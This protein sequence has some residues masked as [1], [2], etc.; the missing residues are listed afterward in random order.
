MELLPHTSSWVYGVFQGMCIALGPLQLNLMFLGPD[1]PMEYQ[2][3]KI[4]FIFQAYVLV[5]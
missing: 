4:F 1:L 5:A 3:V 2:N